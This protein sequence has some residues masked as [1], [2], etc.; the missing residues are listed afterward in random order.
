MSKHIREESSKNRILSVERLSM[1]FGG[2]IAVNDV[3]LH[4]EK[5]EIVGL[6]GANGAGKTTLFN[7]I[8]GVYKPTAGKIFFEGHAVQ[9]LPCQRMCHLG[10]GRT[11]QIVKP[12]SNLSVLDNVMVGALERHNR[13]ARARAKAEEIIE[14]V[15]LSHRRDVS[16]EHLNLP[17]LKRMELARALATEPK[18]LLLDEVMAGLNPVE[19]ARVIDIVRKLND[20]VG[21]TV[22][23]IEHVMKAIMTLSHRIF[24]LNQG[25]LIA[26]GAPEV[27]TN[28]PEVIK[29]YL[30]EK[31]YDKN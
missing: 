1:K 13:V 4:V 21:I 30:G 15:G 18:L 19:N 2:L 6:I 12:F 3:S 23:V 26:Q 25:R 29:S 5:G 24:V 8:A 17:E 14:L 27:V 9:G 11:Y 10:I 20:R 31:R 22:I 28:D 16:G 7:L